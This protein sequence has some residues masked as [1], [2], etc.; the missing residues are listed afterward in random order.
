MRSQSR[1]EL[2]YGLLVGIYV[3]FL[4]ALVVRLILRVF[5][6]ALLQAVAP[7]SATLAIALAAVLGAF[8]VLAFV[9]GIRY[10]LTHCLTAA[11]LPPS[12]TLLHRILGTLALVLVILS[13]FGLPR[14][15]L[16]SLA[17]AT[18]YLQ[19][20]P[21]L[22]LAYLALTYPKGHQPNNHPLGGREGDLTR[23]VVDLTVWGL[24]LGLLAYQA[25]VSNT[26]YLL[27]RIHPGESE[28][29]YQEGLRAGMLIALWLT[30][31]TLG[32]RWMMTIAFLVD[33]KGDLLVSANF[34]PLLQFVLVWLSLAPFMSAQGGL[35]AA[36][37]IGFGLCLGRIVGRL[38]G[39]LLLGQEGPPLL[40]PMAEVVLALWLFPL[41]QQQQ[42][43]HDFTSQNA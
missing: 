9:G 5:S 1:E 13:L 21:T 7:L 35:R 26:L 25:C 40:E 24:L 18:A 42:H 38:I 30:P 33:W 16:Q 11:T 23:L 39:A 29:Y 4:G 19:L 20:L 37:R 12:W 43:P 17:L 32:A 6:G 15:G 34:V 22:V 41:I 36:L 8:L 10:L 14:S 28:F 3:A 27:F 31:A 2:L